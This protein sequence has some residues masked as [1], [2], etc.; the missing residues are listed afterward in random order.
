MRLKQKRF[1]QNHHLVKPTEMGGEGWADIVKSVYNAGVKGAKFLYNNKD[2]IMKVG[3]KALDLYSGP[4]GTM[5]KN[6]LPNSDENGRPSFPGE[7]HTVLELPNGRYGT[8]NFMGPSTHI[9]ARLRRGDPPRTLTDKVAM[10]HDIRYALANNVEDIRKADNIMLQKVSE[11][12]KNKS[13]SM[14]NIIQAKAIYAKTLGE[15]LGVLPRGSFSKFAKGG[16]ISE[17]SDADKDLLK[18][19]LYKLG[20]EVYGHSPGMLPGQALKMNLLK[21]EMKNSKL[22]M[23]TIILSLE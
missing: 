16:P 14:K 4:Q 15:D 5:V 20:Q 23:V 6:M 21:K 11:I 13:D 19:H 3:E 22:R 12:E 17:V 18:G 2:T 7:K 10:G 1:H 9:G 8:A